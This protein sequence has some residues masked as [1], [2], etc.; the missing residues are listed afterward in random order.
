MKEL[1]LNTKTMLNVSSLF[2]Q[3]QSSATNRSKT[4]PVGLHVLFKQEIS[5]KHGKKINPN[6]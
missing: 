5:R 6:T 2:V 3:A 4:D 1:K